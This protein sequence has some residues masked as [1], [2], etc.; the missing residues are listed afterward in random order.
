MQT[1]TGKRPLLSVY[2]LLMGVTWRKIS[3]DRTWGIVSSG[4]LG[5]GGFSLVERGPWLFRTSCHI[6]VALA[7]GQYLVAFARVIPCHYE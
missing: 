1:W 3:L 7:E 5:G 2:N 6:M 4:E